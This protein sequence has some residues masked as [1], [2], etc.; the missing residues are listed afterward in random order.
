[1]IDNVTFGALVKQAREELGITKT[2]LAEITGV[3]ISA[4]YRIETTVNYKASP[5]VMYI[6]SE[7]LGIDEAIEDMNSVRKER[8]KR[9]LSV[10]KVSELAGVPV[11]VLQSLERGFN[12]RL[13]YKKKICDFFKVKP[14]ELFLGKMRL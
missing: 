1:M 5:H 2:K 6:L 11:N 7:E 12:V 14:S 13:D 8:L 4:I 10:Q 9:R 3:S